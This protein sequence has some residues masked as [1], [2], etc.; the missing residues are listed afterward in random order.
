MNKR[1]KRTLQMEN[2]VYR[3][4]NNTSICESGTIHPSYPSL[5]PIKIDRK[6]QN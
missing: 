2:D 4:I 6:P 3:E 5:I 1:W